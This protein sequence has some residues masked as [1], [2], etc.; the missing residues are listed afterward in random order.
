MDWL[1]TVAPAE[2]GAAFVL[3]TV[4]EGPHAPWWA[5]TEGNPASLIQTGQ[6]CAL[7]YAHG[8]THPWLE[9]AAE[10]MWSRLAALTEPQAYEMF[11]VLAFLEHVPDRA[12]AEETFERIGPLLQ[13]SGI[14]ELDPDAA[15]ETHGPLAFAA[16]PIFIAMLLVMR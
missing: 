10:V 13:S 11:G 6:I 9:R 5:A 12:R 14:V 8:F 15:G 3:P 2:G 4:T 1:V 7:L 16:C